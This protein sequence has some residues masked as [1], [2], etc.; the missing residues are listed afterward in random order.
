MV[1]S[2]LYWQIFE[3]LE[4]SHRE[5]LRELWGRLFELYVFELLGHYYPAMSQ[6]LP[7]DVAYADG[8]IDALLDLGDIV[9]VF[10]QSFAAAAKR[11]FLP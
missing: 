7:V 6:M 3:S 10:D 8:Q 5:R 2:G 11:T 1:S 9:I 4:G